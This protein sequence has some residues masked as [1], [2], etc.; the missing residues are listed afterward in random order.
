MAIHTHWQWAPCLCQARLRYNAV[1]QQNTQHKQYPPSGHG[2]ERS[3]VPLLKLS[4]TLR[5]VLRV[6]T[7][8]STLSSC[9][10]LR[11]SDLFSA[12]AQESMALLS[13]CILEWA[14]IFFPSTITTYSVILTR[15]YNIPAILTLHLWHLPFLN[16][17]TEV[18]VWMSTTKPYPIQ[19]AHTLHPSALFPKYSSLLS[20][21]C[22]C[23]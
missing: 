22:A 9:S 15:T 7:Q 12:R 18:M 17:Q 23:H 14:F 13:R 20:Q 4:L 21:W 11:K 5:Q 19:A 3:P 10:V 6:Y 1:Q 2:S 8:S 16:M